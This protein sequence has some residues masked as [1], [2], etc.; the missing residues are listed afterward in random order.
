[1]IGGSTKTPVFVLTRQDKF[2]GLV[3]RQRISVTEQMKSCQPPVDTI[4][5]EVL[6]QPILEFIFSLMD[7]SIAVRWGNL[8]VT[9]SIKSLDI[10]HMLCDLQNQLSRKPLTAASSGAGYER[11]E[12][13]QVRI[14][15]RWHERRE[16]NSVA[17]WCLWELA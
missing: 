9:H 2:D 7:T 16:C 6:G 11:H 10:S 4:E 5:T 3:S 1:V 17:E 13:C 15:L 12:C 14:E 8:Q